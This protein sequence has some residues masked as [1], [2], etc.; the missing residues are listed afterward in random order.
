MT[1]KE[2]HNL[3]EMKFFKRAF[4]GFMYYAYQSSLLCP[5][6]QIFAFFFY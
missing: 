2:E 6:T 4:K 5:Y 1:S 3:C